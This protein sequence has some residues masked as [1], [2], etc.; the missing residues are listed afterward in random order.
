DYTRVTNIARSR[1]EEVLSQPFNGTNLTVPTGQTSLTVDDYF[2]K[3]TQQWTTTLPAKVDWHRNTVIT[4]YS[5]G[6][7]DPVSLTFTN[8][9]SGSSSGTF[10]HLKQVQVTVTSASQGSG[11][12]GHRRQAI[13][14]VLKAF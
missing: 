12:L 11:I 14:R 1:A 4:Q 5:L 8:P 9:L 13:M 10:V 6:N 7:L 2:D 3:A